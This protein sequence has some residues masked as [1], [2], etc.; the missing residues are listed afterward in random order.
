VRW[1]SVPPVLHH[2]LSFYAWYEYTKEPI[3]RRVPT[4]IAGLD[5]ILGGGLSPSRTYLLQGRPG[6]G[7]TTIA[8][9]YLLEG[10][11]G[12]EPGLYVT[13]SETEQE[14]R[15]VADSHGWS[16]DG[17]QVFDLTSSP[18]AAGAGAQYTFFHPAEVEL[19]EVVKRVF[20]EAER[21]KP[22]RVVVDSL[23]EL[24]LLSRDPLRYR[25][26]VLALKQFFSAANATLLLL[27]EQPAETRMPRSRVSCTAS[28]PSTSAC[29]I[30]G[31]PA[32]G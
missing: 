7:K 17:V 28:S 16:L 9:E 11:R 8:L 31:R 30:T 1:F 21:V 5:D 10:V 26:Q 32:A 19:D 15:Q 22:S 25:R 2:P 23:T 6:T 18:E 12:G 3:G 13:L 27:T 24:R 29:R 4:G 14:V 20:D